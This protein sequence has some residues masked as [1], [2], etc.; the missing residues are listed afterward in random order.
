MADIKQTQDHRWTA[1]PNLSTEL[2]AP[3]GAGFLVSQSN[4]VFGPYVNVPCD[5]SS[6][7]V[8]ASTVSPPSWLDSSGNVIEPGLYAC[9]AQVGVSTP[10]TATGLIF[11][12]ASWGNAGDWLYAMDDLA[13][14]PGVIGQD[15]TLALVAGDL[16]YPA[17]VV[18]KSPTD[19]TGV[20]QARAYIQR[21]LSG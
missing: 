20:I 3:A 11:R 14:A 15:E 21:L 19:A 16:S 8:A 7:I 9:G 10:P 12:V 13:L 1:D 2:P 5:G 6:H 17:T 4:I 18:V